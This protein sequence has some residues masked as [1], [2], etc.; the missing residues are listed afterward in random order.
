MTLVDFYILKENAAGDRFMLTCR[1][2]EK[3]YQAGKRVC[4]NT[5]TREEA[6]HLNDLLWQ[7]NDQSFIPH[8]L[9]SEHQTD[10]PVVI[11]SQ[12]KKT[13][14]HQVLINLAHEVPTCFS[15]FERLLE[16]VDH[17]ENCRTAGRVRY[18]YYKDSGYTINNH[19][20]SR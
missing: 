13:D 20:I 18:R 16:P 4:I 6:E 10:T 12:I 8:D 14:E 19:E 3:A 9:D 2:C 17:D 11:T 7:Y 1:L 15:Q 5:Q